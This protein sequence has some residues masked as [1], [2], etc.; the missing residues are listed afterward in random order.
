MEE[1]IKYKFYV[2][3]GFVG[4]SKQE[5]IEIPKSQFKNCK[6]EED[7]E[8]VAQEWFNEWLWENIEATFYKID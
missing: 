4:A 5:I 6:N 2:S 3:T 8:K 1:M 7:V